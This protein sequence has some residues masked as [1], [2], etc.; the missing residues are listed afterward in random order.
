MNV[1]SLFFDLD[2]DLTFHGPKM[3]PL[4]H[5]LGVDDSISQT[6]L[7]SVALGVMVLAVLSSWVVSRKLPNVDSDLL[8][9]I[10][11]FAVGRFVGKGFLLS[12]LS[13]DVF[14]PPLR[15]VNAIYL[16]A[17]DHAEAAPQFLL[18]AFIGSLV[19]SLLNFLFIRFLCGHPAS[20]VFLSP[21]A[22]LAIGAILSQP[23]SWLS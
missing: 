21:G 20:P 4:S 18:V 14:Q 6:K 5:P 7:I 22:S 13:T 15:F 12:F 19:C 16:N 3:N 1:I 17:H 8:M 9:M 2:L 10:F 11:G 23:N